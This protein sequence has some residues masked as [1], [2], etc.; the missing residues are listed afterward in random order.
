MEEIWAKAHKR[1]PFSKVFSFANFLLL[2]EYKHIVK[3]YKV[4]SNGNVNVGS[5]KLLSPQET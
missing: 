5:M 3:I 4:Q 1:L 2:L